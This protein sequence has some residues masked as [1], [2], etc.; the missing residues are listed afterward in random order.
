MVKKENEKAPSPK[1]A[2]PRLDPL[3]ATEILTT[4]EAADYLKCHT[5]TIKN[6]YY[7]GILKGRKVGHTLIFRQK[8]LESFSESESKAA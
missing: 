2:R 5:Q 7:K 3:L 6:M 4:A 8:E 1:N